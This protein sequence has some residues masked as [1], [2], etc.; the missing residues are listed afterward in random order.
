LNLPAGKLESR[1]ENR[2]R[3]QGAKGRKPDSF[4]CS[5]QRGPWEGNSS[6]ETDT[7]K[8]RTRGVKGS[9]KLRRVL[10]KEPQHRNK[11]LKIT[12]NLHRFILA[13]SI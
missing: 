5:G 8:S 3:R 11:T 13:E 2:R 4:D 10:D 12:A 7:S 1:W 9:Q 6:G